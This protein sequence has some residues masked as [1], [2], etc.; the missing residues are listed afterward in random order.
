MK[1]LFF[2]NILSRIKQYINIIIIKKS[3]MT[4]ASGRFV[5][6]LKEN[7]RRKREPRGSFDFLLEFVKH[8]DE[9]EEFEEF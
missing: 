4:N 7:Q 5:K 1:N 9:A 2:I 6:I 3:E 8:A